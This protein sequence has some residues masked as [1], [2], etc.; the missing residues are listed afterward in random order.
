MGPTYDGNGAGAEYTISPYH[1]GLSWLRA[2]HPDATAQIG[3][4]VYVTQNAVI[5]G[6]IG[7]YGIWTAGVFYG[8]GAGITSLNASNLSSGILP[9][10]RLSGTYTGVNI[11]GNAATATKW[12]T[13]R[14]VTFTGGAT[15]SVSL[16]GSANVSVSLAVQPSA[17]THTTAQITG[18]DADLLEAAPPGQ[19]AA[20]ARA[21][22]PAGWLKANGAAVSRT[23]YAQLFAAIGTQ[24]GAGDGSS[25][26][27]LPDMR[28]EFIRGLADGRNLDLGRVLGSVQESQNLS[29][30]H[31]ASVASAGAHT[32]AVSGTAAS[33]GSHTHNTKGA[34]GTGATNAFAYQ[35]VGS[36]VKATDAAGDHTH[37][38]SGTAASAGAHTHTVT[39]AADGGNE[40]RPRNVALLYC[41]KI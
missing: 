32:H 11:T 40:A 14:T 39:I 34:S 10:A 9:D 36:V 12:A 1:Y 5:K 7:H 37:T 30:D 38:V 41:I 28:G 19:V 22:A 16:D 21:T 6:G 35:D 29:H 33:A 2:S 3:E 27:N 26:F 24:F 4:G 25:T 23:A 8:N 15:G 18:L 17:H 20:F 31:G 13:P